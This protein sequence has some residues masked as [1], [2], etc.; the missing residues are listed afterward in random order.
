MHIPK[1]KQDS[2]LSMNIKKQNKQINK[3]GKQLTSI[4]MWDVGR[5]AAQT[6]VDRQ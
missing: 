5:K 3:T 4:M 6:L 1:K 2:L